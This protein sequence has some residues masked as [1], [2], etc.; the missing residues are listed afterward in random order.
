VGR[1]VAL[2]EAYLLWENNF[3]GRIP[4][5]HH[6]DQAR[7]KHAAEIGTLMLA[8]R[9]GEATEEAVCQLL[10]DLHRSNRRALIGAETGRRQVHGR[11]AELAEE[12][13]ASIQAKSENA[14]RIKQQKLQRAAKKAAAAALGAD[15]K[16][17]KANKKRAAMSKEQGEQLLTATLNLRRYAPD[18]REA[19]AE[20][21]EA[22]AST[23]PVELGPGREH[24]RRCLDRLQAAMPAL[25]AVVARS[26]EEEAAAEAA[27]KGSAEAEWWRF[28]TLREVPMLRLINILAT[29]VRDARA[30]LDD[31]RTAADP[32][33]RLASAAPCSGGVGSTTRASTTRRAG[34]GGPAMPP[35]PPPPHLPP[36]C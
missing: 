36:G 3:F 9:D 10:Y 13:L 20:A 21:K 35:P 28:T 19:A 23:L 25:E 6:R 30:R 34:P 26:L 16:P 4:L 11:V 12:A 24:A 27:V 7:Q 22:V 8:L 32:T 18:V 29:Q 2:V 33:V 5:P 31:A 15:G 1:Q 17:A 14:A